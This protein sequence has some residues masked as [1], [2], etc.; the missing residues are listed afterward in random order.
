M[1]IWKN[2]LL[3]TTLAATLTTGARAEDFTKFGFS[4]NDVERYKELGSSIGS[5]QAIRALDGYSMKPVV[6]VARQTRIV[7]LYGQ[8]GKALEREH[9]STKVLRVNDTLLGLQCIAL[10][11]MGGDV[12]GTACNTQPH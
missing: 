10:G 12:D 1:S 8:C 6:D 11:G 3:G 9:A 2:L 5:C 4:S 7:N